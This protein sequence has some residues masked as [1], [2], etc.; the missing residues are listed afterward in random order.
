MVRLPTLVMVKAEPTVPATPLTVKAETVSELST[1][2]SFVRILPVTEATSSAAVAESA[3][4][5]G[6]SL[7]ALTV[8]VRV[9]VAVAA[10][11]ETV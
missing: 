11:S 1:S 2:V 5:T 6:A 3:M 4:A 9:D 8:S 10:P 7:T